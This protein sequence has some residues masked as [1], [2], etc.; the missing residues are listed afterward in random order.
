MK[1]GNPQRLVIKPHVETHGR[2]C[3]QIKCIMHNCGHIPSIINRQSS[4]INHQ[5]NRGSKNRAIME[6]SFGR[7]I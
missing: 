4:I 3:N 7:R 5:S 6:R 1:N 2:A